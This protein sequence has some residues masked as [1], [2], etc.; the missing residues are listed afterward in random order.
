MLCASNIQTEINSNFVSRTAIGTRTDTVFS[1]TST[2]Y[3][4]EIVALQP[5][6]RCMK[7]I[8]TAF[9]LALDE[10]QVVLVA[11][12]A[13]LLTSPITFAVLSTRVQTSGVHPACTVIVCGPAQQQLGT[14]LT[15]D[16]LCTGARSRAICATRTAPFPACYCVCIQNSRKVR[17]KVKV[18]Y[19]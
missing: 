18:N 4:G 17:K 5:R 12:L 1:M 11:L 19:K 7:R 2:D 16:T 13:S 8:L 15:V 14:Y 3:F 6:T 9:D 10:Q